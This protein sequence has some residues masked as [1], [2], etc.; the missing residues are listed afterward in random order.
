MDLCVNLPYLKIISI[1]CKSM[2]YYLLNRLLAVDFLHFVSIQ[3]EHNQVNQFDQIYHVRNCN[4][5]FTLCMISWQKQG[6]QLL[7]T[8]SLGNNSHPWIQDVGFLVKDI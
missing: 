3:K 6:S 4:A 2:I 1:T 8:G 7:K 5:S